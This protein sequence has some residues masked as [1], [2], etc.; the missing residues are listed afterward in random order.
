MNNRQSRIGASTR[1]GRPA[2]PGA[3]PRPFRSALI[4]LAI[5]TA[6]AAAA[7]AAPAPD[8][9]APRIRPQGNTFPPPTFFGPKPY[10]S[11]ADSPFLADYNAGKLYLED[12]ECNALLVPGVSPSTGSVIGPGGL[13]DSVDADDGVIDG[14]GTNGHSFFAPS[15]SNGID[16][17]FDPRLQPYPTEV[18]IVWTDGGGSTTFE[19]F[20]QFGNSLGQ[21][22]PV[23]IADGSNLG[24]TAE[25]RFFGVL[26]L[27]GV[28][29]IHISNDSGGIEVDHL[30]YGLYTITGAQID[31]SVTDAPDPVVGGTTLTYT[32][33]AFN[34]GPSSACLLTVT[35]PL[36]PGTTFLSA[37]GTGWTCSQASGTVTCIRDN[38]P[39]DT[40]LPSI[41]IQVTAPNV[42]TTLTNTVTASS[43]TFDPILSDNT[44]TATTTVNGSCAPVTL[45]PTSLPGGTLGVAYSQTLSALPAAAYTFAVTAGSL[46]TGLTLSSGGLL[47]G[48]PTATGSYN[49]TVTATDP[50]ACTGSQAYSVGISAGSCTPPLAPA[51]TAKPAVANIGSRI[52]LSWTGTLTAGQG[53]YLLRDSIN[54]GGFVDLATIPSSGA[55]KETFFF[56]LPPNPGTYDFRVLAVPACNPKL[57]AASNI[58]EVLAS[59]P[60]PNA[61]RVTGVAV[62]PDSAAAGEPFTLTWNP[63]PGFTG[64]YDVLLST[65]GGQNFGLLGT[66]ATTSFSGTVAGNPGTTLTFAVE[67]A[68]CVYSQQSNFATLTV[69]PGGATC[70]PPGAVSGILIRALGVT[71]ARAPSPT[72]FIDVRWDGPAGGTA[73][74]GFSVRLNGETEVVVT[75]TSAVFPPRGADLDPIQAF[76]R[77]QACDPAVSGPEVA[78]D[79]VALFLTPPAASFTVSSNPRAGEAVLFTDTSAP[80]AT[81]WLWVFDDGGTET[82]QAPTHVFAAAG[83]HEVSLIAT[84]SAGSSSATQSIGVEAAG[85]ARVA[86]PATPL[87]I[88]ARDP[89]RRRARVVLPGLDAV[90]L[91]IRSESQAETVVF[92]RFL[93]DAG[94]LLGERRLAVGPGQ[95][96]VYDLGAYGL[97]GSMT[98]E[99]VSGQ[100]Y[101]A[102]VWS[103]G[104]AGTREIVR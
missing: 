59:G 45:L 20:D 75:S 14:S 96:G 94:R 76:V 48:T 71:P 46:P 74:S 69:V 90:H 57:A 73:P 32:I 82:T 50:N 9:G 40:S 89:V 87:R 88:D 29:R 11:K 66:S 13:T 18:G 28:S 62:T 58:A 17:I 70:D 78:G 81:S 15:G 93:D 37:S 84:N 31:V 16:F 6:L 86:P 80:Q 53:N 42:T 35:D 98:L 25:D 63:A 7:S 19:A 72:E 77:A 1:F 54:G 61:P 55:S 52:T 36:P 12:F 102:Q 103:A 56:T 8:G 92:A 68:G 47:S 104:H 44:A 97:R 23:A 33:S 30:Q 85:T 10:L 3:A 100:M 65:D 21:I 22:G 99:L 24:T 39:G 41:T 95:E 43:N 51:L 38:A 34:S 60:C 64:G 83:P 67:P 101:E 5:W 49:F 79:P 26:Y 4:C 91:R 27:G 2:A